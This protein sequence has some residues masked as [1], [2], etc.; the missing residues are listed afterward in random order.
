MFL[1]GTPPTALYQEAITHLRN[2]A[3]IFSC[4]FLLAKQISGQL[5]QYSVIS[6]I[7]WMRKLKNFCFLGCNENK[8][9]M[10]KSVMISWL[11]LSIC[12]IVYQRSSSSYCY[13]LA[14][15][16]STTFCEKCICWQLTYLL[17]LIFLIFQ[18]NGPKQNGPWPE[19]NLHQ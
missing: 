13:L 4:F 6:I 14:S 2:V 5:N 11:I 15:V 9:F 19:Q 7:L 3:V 18:Q 17:D 8:S 16:K 10:S 1:Y 12:N